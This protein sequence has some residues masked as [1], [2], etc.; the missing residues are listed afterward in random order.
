MLKKIIAPFVT[1]A[2][3]LAVCGVVSAAEAVSIQIDGTPLDTQP[4]AQI[5]QGRTLVPMRAIFEALGAK[6]DWDAETKTVNAAA[7]GH[8]ISL[9]VGAQS[10]VKDGKSVE[11]SV[12][13]QI[14][15]GRTF[16][17]ARAVSESLDCLVR[18]DGETKT[19]YIETD[20]EETVD[21]VESEKPQW[22]KELSKGVMRPAELDLSEE[23][24]ADNYML[25][26]FFVMVF[27]P[28]LTDI[29]DESDFVEKTVENVGMDRFIAENWLSSVLTKVGESDLTKLILGEGASDALS[30]DDQR[31]LDEVEAMMDT[32][33]L[34]VKPNFSYNSTFDKD[35]TFRMVI[36]KSKTRH[37]D[38]G[39][40]FSAVIK[41][42][43]GARYYVMIAGEDGT[44][45]LCGINNG[46]FETYP[47][48]LASDDGDFEDALVTPDT[49]LIMV[50]TVE[51]N[52]VKPID[53]EKID[54]LSGIETHVI[55]D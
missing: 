14:I 17:P 26:E 30:A 33:K 46:I 31:R 36:A 1:A 39:V 21:Y 43:N 24:A 48:A 35:G 47:I 9:T 25:K 50:D 45:Q 34:N 16:V 28:K 40:V 55:D 38:E 37:T 32:L 51:R 12:P 10:L 44:Y 5:I 41:D 19:V 6:I 3:V 7:N 22:V 53:T 29:M 49:F 27:M 11:L 2:A 18:W 8:S 42:K 23:Y 13:A 15:D 4:P 54:G 52:G 20:A